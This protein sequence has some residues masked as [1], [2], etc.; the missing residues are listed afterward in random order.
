[1]YQEVSRCSLE[2]RNQVLLLPLS[3]TMLPKSGLARTL[4]HGAGVGDGVSVH[5][6]GFLQS[7]HGDEVRQ[8]LIDFIAS[9]AQ[10]KTVLCTSV[11]VNERGGIECGAFC[12]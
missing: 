11:D 9:R 10:I 4:I 2:F 12:R 8:V 3:L 1:L 7:S 6:G 5:P